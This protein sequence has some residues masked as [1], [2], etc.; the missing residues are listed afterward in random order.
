MHRRT[1]VEREGEDDGLAA[2]FLP[3]TLVA[4]RGDAGDDLRFA[5]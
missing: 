5:A 2:G 1:I 4:T 3:V